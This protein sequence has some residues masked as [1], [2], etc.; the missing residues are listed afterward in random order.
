MCGWDGRLV[1]VDWQ[2]KNEKVC[3]GSW[4]GFC[5]YEANV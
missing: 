3:V 4:V 5:G 1:L 2:T